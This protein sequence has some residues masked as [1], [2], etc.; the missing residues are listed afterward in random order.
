MSNVFKPWGLLCLALFISR[1]QVINIF[2]TQVPGSLGCMS[3][4][5]VSRKCST[6]F[7]GVPDITVYLQKRWK[8]FIKNR[9]RHQGASIW[10]EI[11]WTHTWCFPEWRLEGS[12]L[13]PAPLDRALLNA[14][15]WLPRPKKKKIKSHSQTFE[16]WCSSC[17]RGGRQTSQ[18]AASHDEKLSRMLETAQINNSDT[19][20]WRVSDAWLG[21]DFVNIE[22]GTKLVICHQHGYK[23]TNVYLCSAHPEYPVK[24]FLVNTQEVA[25]VFS[26]NDGGSTRWICNE[27][28]LSKVVTLMERTHHT[29][30]HTHRNVHIIRHAPRYKL[31]LLVIFNAEKMNWD[32][33]AALLTLLNHACVCVC[34][35]VISVHA[36][37]WASRASAPCSGCKWV[38]V[39]WIVDAHNPL[40]PFNHNDES[41]CSEQSLP[42][43]TAGV[44]PTP[45]GR[46][47]LVCSTQRMHENA[48]EWVN[49]SRNT[50]LAID[51]HVDR[52]L[53]N[54]VP[55]CAF[56]SLVEHWKIKDEHVIHTYCIW[57]THTQ[58]HTLG[59]WLHFFFCLHP[60]SLENLQ[61]DYTTN[62]NQ[63]TK[64]KT[65]HV[66]LCIQMHSKTKW[67]N[68][69]SHT[70]PAFACDS[71][72]TTLASSLF[73]CKPECTHFSYRVGTQE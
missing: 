17:A 60:L 51:H 31:S 70:V 64:Q 1:A 2:S 30:I 19:V 69:D 45:W 52:T 33:A 53:L 43:S 24:V 67:T 28:Q 58:T 54:D 9:D 59:S 72:I 12:F 10:Q 36:N 68:E 39:V 63:R 57:L 41:L 11:S 48:R 61:H 20:Q 16:M 4:L 18:C 47:L 25:V 42:D 23:R 5:M 66:T 46:L 35:C 26:Q 34:T 37:S 73:T 3:I 29:L 13:T 6:I 71:K 8:G 49:S 50:H 62:Q 32:R 65:M 15:C 27:G 55:W 38:C 7:S 44:S 22:L 14:L 56:L 40:K 21:G